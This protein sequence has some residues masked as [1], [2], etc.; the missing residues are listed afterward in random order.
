[1]SNKDLLTV[2]ESAIAAEQGWGL[3]H[4][5]DSTRWVVKALGIQTPAAP[6]TGALIIG[7]AR[8]GQQPAT[9]A[10]QLIMKNHQ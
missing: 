9:R 5:Y 7:L 4:V 10:L 3:F 2:E 1:M 8:Q 6:E